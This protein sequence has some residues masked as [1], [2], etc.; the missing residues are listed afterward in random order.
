MNRALTWWRGLPKA[1]QV[2]MLA[3]VPIVAALA[4]LQ[5][6][7]A[8]ATRADDKPTDGPS[9]GNDIAQASGPYPANPPPAG[10]AL[11]A[12]DLGSFSRAVTEELARWET[13]IEH[14]EGGV[15][16]EPD[17]VP[18]DASGALPSWVT[19]PPGTRPDPQQL[20][21]LRR[22]AALQP[23]TPAYAEAEANARGLDVAGAAERARAILARPENQEG[24][25]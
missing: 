22:L 3:G 2:L 9:A 21:F 16:T 17:P 19:I 10:Y 23:G 8:G 5:R 6:R 24:G 4:L 7:R 1:Q 18:V 12:A 11:S 25:Q 15:T 20:D 14:L 13:R